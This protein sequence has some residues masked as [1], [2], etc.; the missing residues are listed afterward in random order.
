VHA[1][2]PL[3]LFF[4]VPPTTRQQNQSGTEDSATSSVKPNRPWRQ[5]RKLQACLVH[6]FRSRSIVGSF[7]SMERFGGERVAAVQAA[8][9]DSGTSAMTPPT[10]WSTGYMPVSFVGLTRPGIPTLSPR[11]VVVRV[12]ERRREAEGVR[13]RELYQ[14]RP[15]IPAKN[16]PGFLRYQTFPG[17]QRQQCVRKNATSSLCILQ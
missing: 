10:D 3:R 5:V 12:G 16:G 14:P 17:R 1:P 7:S 4:M 6:K 8:I 2:P 9:G 13:R 15:R 11:P